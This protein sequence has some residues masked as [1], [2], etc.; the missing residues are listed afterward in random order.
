MQNDQSVKVH[1]EVSITID[2]A[3]HKSP[4]PTTGIA[5]YTLGQVP[6]GYDLYR[7]VHGKGDDEFIPNNST[8]IELHEGDHFYTVQSTL[9]PGTHDA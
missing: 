9:N 2:K 1:Q 4:N 3:R 8:E 5:L 6:Q 7:E